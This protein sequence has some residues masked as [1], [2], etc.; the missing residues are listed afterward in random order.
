MDNNEAIK[1]LRDIR[2]MME[3]SSRFQA[4]SGWGL[5][6]IGILALTA[7]WIAHAIFSET[8]GTLFGDTERLWAH[9]TQVAVYGSM[10]LVCICGLIVFLSSMIMARRKGIDFKFDNTMR[11]VLI[12]FTVPLLAGGLLCLA[13]VMQ[14]HYGLTSSIM[15]IFY[16]LALI[17]CHHFS[18]PTLGLLGY[19][20]LLLG[21]IDCFVATHALL[22]WTIGFGVLHI[23]AGISFI[24]K[25]RKK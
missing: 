10:I 22:F 3:K 13:L 19:L 16:G 20:E 23:V 4:I 18:H 21:L 11:R 25:E 5:T 14:H 1:D 15:L 2:A 7:S 12:N 6:I 17:N 9:K 8:G 24:I